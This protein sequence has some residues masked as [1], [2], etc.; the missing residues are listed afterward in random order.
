MPTGS[1][2]TKPQ[3]SIEAQ[4]LVILQRVMA[5][6]SVTRAALAHDSGIHPSQITNMFKGV[7]T[8]RFFEVAAMCDALGLRL[9]DVLAEAEA[10]AG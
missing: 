7:K 9:S 1:T 5:E 3:S 4:V 6:R 8:A 2:S 10:Q